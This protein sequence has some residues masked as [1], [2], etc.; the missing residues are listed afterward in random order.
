MT[1]AKALTLSIT[2]VPIFG[3]RAFKEMIKL[4]QGRPLSKL[5]DIFIKGD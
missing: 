1:C 4:K 5:I 2:E 3:N